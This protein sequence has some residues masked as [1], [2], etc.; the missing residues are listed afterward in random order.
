[1]V[2]CEQFFKKNHFGKDLY[3]KYNKYTMSRK[4]RYRQLVNIVEYISFGDI[5][6]AIVE[7]GVWKGGCLM[8][9]MDM[10]NRLDDIR[11]IWAYDTFK[12]LIGGN[13]FDV[14]RKGHKGSEMTG[15]YAV[16]MDEVQENLKLVG[17]TLGNIKMVKGDVRQSC[18]RH[19]P[20]EIALLRVD[21]DFYEATKVV[22]E[23]MYPKL[24]KGG[25]VIL[26]DYETWLG[27]RK[28]VDEFFGSQIDKLITRRDSSAAYWIKE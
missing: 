21:V 9:I 23:V 3:A 12:G 22:L 11:E 4:R 6:G 2:D 10:L 13:E 15:D 16:S 7:C 5:D 8:G 17:Y 20:K 18:K 19:C 27:S 25:V 14:N 26:D 1:M 24:S 28:A